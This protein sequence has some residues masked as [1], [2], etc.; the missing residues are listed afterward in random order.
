MATPVV[1]AD[2]QFTL[3][4]ESTFGTT[5]GSTPTPIPTEN[6]DINHDSKHHAVVRAR[7]LRGQHEDDT[8]NDQVNSIPTASTGFYVTLG[9]HVW[10][11]ACLQK[12]V[13]WT[14]T[15]DDWIYQTLNY[16][17][18]PDFSADE[19]Y[20][21]TLAANGPV[22]ARDERITS[23]IAN[24]I[25]FSIAPDANEGS[26]FCEM[27]WV[28]KSS[29]KAVTQ[30]GTIASPPS[31]TTLQKWSDITSVTV[32]GLALT[33]DFYSAE[34]TCSNNAKFV[35]AGGSD[36]IALPR[37]EVT[38]SVE[39]LAGTAAEALKVYVHSSSP[40]TGWPFAI[41]FN[42]GDADGDVRLESHCYFTNW[43]S[44]RSEEEKIS[45][46]FTGVFGGGAN[47]VPLEII[48]FES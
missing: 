17:D 41:Q 47:E 9:T 26:L 28:G 38:G 34:I 8:W 48:V 2:Y 22:A 23:A 18:M 16:A 31:M 32:S 36:N 21:Y 45:F 29:Q 10:F 30:A 43:S 11:P 37:W 25:K 35:P 27:E 4:K 13:A 20:F 6:V 24:S 15:S 14:Q 5:I 46:E 33:D 39:I 19:G 3:E 12:K 42:D 44:D 1:G 40:S 7:G